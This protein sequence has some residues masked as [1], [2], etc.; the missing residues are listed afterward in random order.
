MVLLLL[1]LADRVDRQQRGVR[2]GLLFWFI[3]LAPAIPIVVGQRFLYLPSVGYSLA[4]AAA[5]ATWFADRRLQLALFTLLLLAAAWVKTLF[6]EDLVR[7]VMVPLQELSALRAE[8][9]SGDR[10]YFV[11]LP[12]LVCMGFGAAMRQILKRDDLQVLALTLSPELP[13]SAARLLDE[14]AVGSRTGMRIDAQGRLEL[15][16]AGGEYFASYMERFFLWGL[17]LPDEG[18]LVE[19]EGLRVE[20]GP[21][22]PRGGIEVLSFGIEDG[23]DAAHNWVFVSDA[24]GWHRIRSADLSP[25]FST[26]SVARRRR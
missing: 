2:L 17:A 6:R 8:F 25:H 21:R 24:D 13:P 18:S 7:V 23:L 19:A 1:F 22:G 9:Q 12:P 20:I 10:L 4:L 16:R 11:D 14:E 5:L 26:D 15:R 3:S